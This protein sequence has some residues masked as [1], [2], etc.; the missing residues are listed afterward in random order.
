MLS[1]RIER[2]ER[3]GD[4]LANALQRHLHSS[5]RR[6]H[7]VEAALPQALERHARRPRE[8]LASLEARLAPV[9]ER[10]IARLKG[11]VDSHAASLNALSPLAVLERGYAMPRDAS[12]KVLRRRQDFTPGTPFKLRV[13]DGEITAR[14]EES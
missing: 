4:R 13:S 11:V 1:R 8:R 6:L 3:S 5:E 9:M 10:R 2:V 7:A 14:T 12:G